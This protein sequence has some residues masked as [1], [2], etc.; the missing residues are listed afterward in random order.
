MTLSGVVSSGFAGFY[1]SIS[2]FPFSH[3]L[4]QTAAWNLIKITHNV[5]L[6]SLSR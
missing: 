3:V 6:I 1:V 5:Y 2:E 4:A